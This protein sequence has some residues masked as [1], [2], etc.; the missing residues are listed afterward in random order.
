[1]PTVAV[2]PKPFV[3]KDMSLEN[4]TDNFAA[5][6]STATLTPTVS[7]QTW[8]G[9]TPAAVYQDA[10]SADWALSLD[11]AQDWETPKSLS[12]YLFDNEGKSV[13]FTLTP[14]NGKGT[15]WTVT[16]FIVPG[17][18]GGA[19]GSFAAASV[20]LPVTGRPVPAAVTA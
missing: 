11:Y 14:T 3:L 20:T 17:A 12:R 10:A 9:G 16:V 4:P 8:K 6:V 18:V 7:V 2:T 19:I 15:R 5:Q 13:V 1:M